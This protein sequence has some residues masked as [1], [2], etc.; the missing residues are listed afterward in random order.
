MNEKTDSYQWW[1]RFHDEHHA[2]D[3]RVHQRPWLSHG[4]IKH[5]DCAWCLRG[6]E[7][8]ND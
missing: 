2:D 7:G 4:E 8:E 6:T 3:S 5:I 1:K